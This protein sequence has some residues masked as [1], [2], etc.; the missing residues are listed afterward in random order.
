MAFDFRP[1]VRDRTS[2]LVGLA[3]ASGSG[4]TFSALKLATGL[5]GPTGK[6][7]FIDT[8]R[9]RAKHYAPA[10]GVAADPTRG[11]FTFGH[12]E[13]NPPFTPTAYLDAIKAADEA[14]YTVIVVDSFSH[15]WEGEGGV[16]D[17]QE[18]EFQRM[19]ARDAVKMTSW[20]KPKAAHKKLVSRL[21]Q[22]RAHLVICMR[23]QEKLKVVKGANGKQEIIASADRPVAER[24]EPIC[25]KRFPYELTVSFVLT[26]DNPGVP[27]PVK[28]QD[29][30]RP[31]FPTDQ[32]IDEAAGSALAA[33]ST[34]AAEP[35]RATPT[36]ALTRGEVRQLE[37]LIQQAIA[38]NAVKPSQAEALEAAIGARDADA[39][40]AGIRELADALTEAQAGLGV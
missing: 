25:D 36:G 23:A 30:H 24:W 26:P 4:K 14:G 15:E 18:A 29:Q 3:G 11:T 33:W 32:R 20:I 21:V 39:V 37:Q 1:A 38:A 12:A 8:E 2:V 28:L 19:G 40:R 5:A 16:L 7:A 9:G 31:F 35:S 22:C 34:G 17:M 6:I 10:P 13:L 27:V